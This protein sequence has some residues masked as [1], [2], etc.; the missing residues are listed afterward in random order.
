MESLHPYRAVTPDRPA[1][2]RH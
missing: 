1:G 2:G